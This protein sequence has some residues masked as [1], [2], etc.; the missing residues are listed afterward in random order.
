[1]YITSQQS[2]ANAKSNLDPFLVAVLKIAVNNKQNSPGGIQSAAVDRTG[3]ARHQILCIKREREI[4]CL[5]FPPDL[6]REG[7]GLYTNSVWHYW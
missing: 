2:G 4:E 5:K 1:M 6:A 3:I 7:K